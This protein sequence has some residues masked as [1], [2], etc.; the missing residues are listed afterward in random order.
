MNSEA[1]NKPPRKPLPSDTIEASAFRTKTPA[2][3]ASD[4][5]TIEVKC[6]APWPD[7]ITCGVTSAISPTARPPSAGRSGGQRLDLRQHRLA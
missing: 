2:I 4:S 3:M 7:A 6:S 5:D 1:K